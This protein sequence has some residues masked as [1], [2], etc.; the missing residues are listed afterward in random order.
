MVQEDIEYIPCIDGTLA[1]HWDI[2][3]SKGS[4][5]TGICRK[6][7]AEKKFTNS[8]PVGR[9]WK[10][11]TQKSYENVVVDKEPLEAKKDM[12]KTHRDIQIKIT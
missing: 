12:S 2:E 11:V 9:G 1:H 5:S 7:K 10:G 6:C 8:D 3:A 4:L